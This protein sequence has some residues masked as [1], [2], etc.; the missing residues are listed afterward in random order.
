MPSEADI[1]QRASK[2]LF[3]CYGIPSIKL[4]MVNDAGW[5]D[6]LYVLPGGR[7]VWVEYKKPGERPTAIQDER[8][9]LLTAF[10]HTVA[11]YESV[12]EAVAGVAQAL[13]P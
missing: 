1:E 11:T 5:P 4:V 12:E 10:G 8:H 9:D 2:L 3:D 13:G 6:R 7:V